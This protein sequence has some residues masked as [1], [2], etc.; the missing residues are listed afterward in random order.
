MLIAIF[1]FFYLPEINISHSSQ[2][3]FE[4]LTTITGS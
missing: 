2:V 3:R 1:G 4:Q